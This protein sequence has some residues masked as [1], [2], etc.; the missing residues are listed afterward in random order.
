MAIRPIRTIL[1]VAILAGL[2]VPAWPCSVASL[3]SAEKLIRETEVIVRARAEGVSSTPGV[4]GVMAASGTQVRF[5]V[6]DV[7][8]GGLPSSIVEFNGRLT[9]RD[10]PNEHPVP[11]SFIRPAGRGGN[12]FALIYRAGAE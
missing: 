8:K 2:A 10:D 3:A 11:Y 9:D 7:L 6:L 12:C 5:T 4:A 1:T